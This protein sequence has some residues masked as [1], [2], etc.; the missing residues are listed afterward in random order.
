MG[1]V[2][3]RFR[4][5]SGFCRKTGQ[6][7]AQ[8]RQKNRRPKNPTVF[9]RRFFDVSVGASRFFR[10][11]PAFLGGFCFSPPLAFGRAA[12]LGWRP[13]PRGE[14]HGSIPAALFLFLLFLPFRV[15]WLSSAKRCFWES[16]GRGVWKEVPFAAL[17]AASGSALE[18]LPQKK[19]KKVCR[20]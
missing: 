18:G 13:A 7:G 1:L 4:V 12:R 5:F 17:R 15:F 19:R 2:D 10:P 11:R 20:H 3:G 9:G 16:S 6:N 8:K 14:C